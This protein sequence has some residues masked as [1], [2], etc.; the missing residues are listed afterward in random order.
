MNETIATVTDA[1]QASLVMEIELGQPIAPLNLSNAASGKTYTQARCLVRLH[2]RP[3][4]MVELTTEHVSPPALAAQIW[5]KL[6]DRIAAH[7]AEDG[8]PAPATLTEDGLSWPPDPECL[9]LRRA[10]LAD[11]PLVSVVIPTRDRAPLIARCLRSLMAQD[12]PCF[13]LIVVDNAPSDDSTRRTIEAASAQCEKPVRYICEQLPGSS[14]AR[15]RGWQLAKGEII[16]FADDDVLMD[17]HWLTELVGGFQAAKHVGCVTGLVLQAEIETPAQYL[18]GEYG[19]FSKGFDRHIYSRWRGGTP[20]LHPYA[21]G[22]LGTGA[23]MAF[24]REALVRFGGF[25]PHL[26]YGQDI[27]VLFEALIHGYRLVY[28]PGAILYHTDHREYE[29]LKRQIYCYGLGLTGYLTKVVLDHP[30]LLGDMMVRM[31]FGMAYLLSPHS[32]K[33]RNK[34]RTYPAE[35][36]ALERR[37]MWRGPWIYLQDRYPLRRRRSSSKP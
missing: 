21:A 3:L 36:T 20:F 19:G 37:G 1:F 30:L 35:L 7:L 12:Y 2:S 24:L 28:E 15:N 17:P 33:N 13:E 5:S 8:L 22:R 32:H 31:P 14:R 29:A 26:M 9:R 27:A 25:D 6:H 4:G 18:L 11:D 10:A 23:S 34:S 16:A